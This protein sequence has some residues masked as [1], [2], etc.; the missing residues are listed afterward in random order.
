MQLRKYQLFW[1]Q[2]YP[3]GIAVGS[4]AVTAFCTLRWRWT[5]PATV[6]DLF[7]SIVNV[8]AIAIGFLAA[9]QAILFSIEQK[10][11]IQQLKDAEYF[12]FVVDYMSTAIAWSF[13]LALFTSVAMLI[14]WEKQA[15]YPQKMIAAALSLWVALLVVTVLS[16]FR[17]VRV[18]SRLLRDG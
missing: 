3:I 4:G 8:A 18:F 16:Y 13:A 5:P 12:D 2:W 17:V 1:E 9:A 11:I 15:G 6:K 7:P 10:K 14:D